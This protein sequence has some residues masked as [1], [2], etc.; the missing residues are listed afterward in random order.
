MLG[1]AVADPFHQHGLA[2]RHVHAAVGTGHHA[3]CI[4]GLLRPANTQ[5]FGGAAQQATGEIDA[6]QQQE[7][8]NQGSHG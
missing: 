6:G 3:F 1:R 2:L 5:A 4:A 7:E 8:K